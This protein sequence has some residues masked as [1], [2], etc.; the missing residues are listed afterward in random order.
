M[1]LI[2]T[3]FKGAAISRRQRWAFLSA[4]VEQHPDV[5]GHA[6]SFVGRN[7]TDDAVD[8][9][10]IFFLQKI[11]P[12][13]GDVTIAP[14]FGWATGVTTDDIRFVTVPS[15]GCDCTSALQRSDGSYA[16]AD[17][18]F[19]DARQYWSGPNDWS[20]RQTTC[21]ADQTDECSVDRPESFASDSG[22]ANCTLRTDGIIIKTLP[23]FTKIATETTAAG[24][25]SARTFTWS[26][27]AVEVGSS[28]E[29]YME[30]RTTRQDFNLIISPGE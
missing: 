2:R 10:A 27:T 26:L 20:I 8:P 28:D 6:S 1:S 18:C 24:G 7:R 9:C 17:D 30:T 29:N 22:S 16:F 13:L 5:D 12:T 3:S 19:G 4:R 21:G 15:A 25:S 14:E 11:A 23:E